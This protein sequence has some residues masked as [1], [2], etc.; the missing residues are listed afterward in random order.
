ME[1]QTFTIR[2]IYIY[3]F[4]GCWRQT[5]LIQIV[6]LCSVDRADKGDIIQLK[7]IEFTD[8]SVWAVS[9][10][11][12]V[13]RKL[14]QNDHTSC[15]SCSAFIDL[16]QADVLIELL[17]AEN[18]ITKLHSTQIPLTHSDRRSEYGLLS[19]TEHLCVQDADSA[20]VIYLFVIIVNKISTTNCSINDC[21]F[22]ED[23]YFVYF[24]IHTYKD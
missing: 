1:S 22:K 13:P 12:R 6:I 21:L 8:D 15:S 19:H 16:S 4:D 23:F 5:G 3:V 17:A 24:N 2:L 18:W 9:I 14:Q 10:S 7:F 20:T 11:A